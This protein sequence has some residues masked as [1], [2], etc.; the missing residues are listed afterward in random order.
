MYS[1]V[2]HSRSDLQCS[3]TQLTQLINYRSDRQTLI[4]NLKSLINPCPFCRKSPNG[5]VYSRRVTE[6]HCH[7]AHTRRYDVNQRWTKLL[8]DICLDIADNIDTM[9]N[10]LRK[11]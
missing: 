8:S 11:C 3:E 2:L 7:P 6:L 4:I 9:L 5:S 10:W 1:D